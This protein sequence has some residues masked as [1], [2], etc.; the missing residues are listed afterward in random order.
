M[1]DGYDSGEGG[2]GGYDASE[3]PD[4]EANAGACPPMQIWYRIY[5]EEDFGAIFNNP[6]NNVTT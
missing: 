4:V 2:Y 5:P 3:V 1:S 6:P